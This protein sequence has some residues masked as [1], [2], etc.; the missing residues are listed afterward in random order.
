MRNLMTF[1]LF[2]SSTGHNYT[3]DDIKKLPGYMLLLAVGYY[4]T[5]TDVMK[6]HMSMR[7]FND[8]L[9]LSDP[10]DNVIAYC[11]GY[12]RKTTPTWHKDSSQRVMKKFDGPDALVRWNDQF[13]YIYEWTL[14]QYKK[15]GIDSKYK[16]TNKSDFINGESAMKYMVKSYA[17]DPATVFNMY[18]SLDEPNKKKFLRD[19]KNT[20]NDFE[21][22]KRKYEFSMNIVK[23]WVQ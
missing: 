12:V 18:D 17:S 2:E 9:G 10:T 4:E 13:F 11:N 21:D 1:R 6:K 8:E 5:S 14:K 20:K 19:I 7:L 23:N 16:G 3:F 15:H 22:E